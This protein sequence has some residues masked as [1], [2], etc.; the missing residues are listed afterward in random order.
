MSKGALY[1]QFKL[2]L[3]NTC[4]PGDLTV[5]LPFVGLHAYIEGVKAQGG[6]KI[7][8]LINSGKDRIQ[9]QVQSLF[10]PYTHTPSNSVP[11]LLSWRRAPKTFPTWKVICLLYAKKLIGGWRLL[12]SLRIENAPNHV[13]KRLEFS[14]SI[15]ILSK[16]FRKIRGW[17]T[18]WDAWRGHGSSIPPSPCLLLSISSL[19]LS[20]S[21]IFYNKPI[22]VK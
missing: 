14:V 19:L 18:H 5:S 7:S 16:G 12:D 15:K 3:H 11:S 4:H 9:T 10:P 17:W 2:N 22:N 13:I 20:L 6:W 8:I 21:S 1:K